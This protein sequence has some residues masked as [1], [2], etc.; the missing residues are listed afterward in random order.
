MFFLFFFFFKH[1]AAKELRHQNISPSG[2]EMDDVRQLES[3]G[4]SLYATPVSLSV[5]MDT[6]KIKATCTY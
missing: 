1:K 4:E 6:N 5:Y 2:V 3:T